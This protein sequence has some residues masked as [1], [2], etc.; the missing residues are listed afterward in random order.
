MLGLS[1]E[2]NSVHRHKNSRQLAVTEEVSSDKR[3]IHEEL[4]S[5]VQ[6]RPKTHA[7]SH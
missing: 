7:V 1:P 3:Q 5:E 6:P 2:L 4:R